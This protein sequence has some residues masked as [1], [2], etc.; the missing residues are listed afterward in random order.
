MKKVL[1]ICLII[2]LLAVTLKPDN[3]TGITGF[4]IQTGSVIITIARTV[5]KQVL[6]LVIKVL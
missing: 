4:L 2:F 5:I 1:I 6:S 3:L